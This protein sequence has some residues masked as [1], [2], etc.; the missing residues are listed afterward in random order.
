MLSPGKYPRAVGSTGMPSPVLTNRVKSLGVS[1]DHGMAGL[2]EDL[3]GAAN[4]ALAPRAWTQGHEPAWG[5]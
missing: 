1:K 4:P 5:E 2:G 3:W